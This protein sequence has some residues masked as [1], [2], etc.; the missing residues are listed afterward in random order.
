MTDIGIVDMAQIPGSKGFWLLTSDG[1]V[2]SYGD[3]PFYGSY[4]GL[5]PAARQG[6]RTF[7][8]G[9]IAAYPDGGGYI[10]VASSGEAYE[11]NAQVKAWLD[12]GAR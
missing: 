8:G 12:G 10:L 5:P 1:G 4:P 7:K 9:R 2:R 3:A 6:E 11:F